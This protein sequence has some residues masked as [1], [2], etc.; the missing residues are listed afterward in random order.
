MGGWAGQRLC[1][2]DLVAPSLEH[3]DPPDPFSS[4][5][6]SSPRGR[7]GIQQRFLSN[8]F[9]NDLRSQK[10]RA[11]LAEMHNERPVSRSGEKM[12]DKE[13]NNGRTARAEI[14]AGTGRYLWTRRGGVLMF[15]CH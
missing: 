10:S 1:G 15:W 11:F 5:K 8:M 13:T 12:V 9:K 2:H 7:S 6:Q 4:L 14:D 3:R